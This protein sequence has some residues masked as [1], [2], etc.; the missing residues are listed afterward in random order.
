MHSILNN[1]NKKT[2]TRL[3]HINN[4]TT[5]AQR[6]QSILFY[7]FRVLLCVPQQRHCAFVVHKLLIFLLTKLINSS[8]K[9]SELLYADYLT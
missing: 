7:I 2:L 8:A 5:K 4:R 1:I 9:K 3:K 6:T